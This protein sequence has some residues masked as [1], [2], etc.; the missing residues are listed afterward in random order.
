MSSARKE[1][2]K[3]DH[4]DRELTLQ[5]DG[6]NIFAIG[7]EKGGRGKIFNFNFIK[8]KI[9]RGTHRGAGRKVY[10]YLRLPLT[11]KENQDSDQKVRFLDPISVKHLREH[12][13]KNSR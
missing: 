1:A 7:P 12:V 4:E 5:K 9:L 8:P 2:F 3:E 6:N 11:S 10:L 13:K